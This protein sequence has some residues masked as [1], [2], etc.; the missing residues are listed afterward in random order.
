[1]FALAAGNA[2]TGAALG[3]QVLC[4]EGQVTLLDGILASAVLAGLAS[5]SLPAGGSADPLA[6]YLLV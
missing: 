3:N 6:G 4:T 1:M 2:R 5:T